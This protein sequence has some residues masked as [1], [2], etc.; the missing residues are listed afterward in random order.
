M[1]PSRSK[2]ARICPS[3]LLL[4]LGKRPGLSGNNFREK[5]QRDEIGMAPSPSRQTLLPRTVTLL[6]KLLGPLVTKRTENFFKK[7]E[8]SKLDEKAHVK[9]LAALE[10]GDYA[11]Y[12]H[13]PFC[14]TPLCKF[15]CF[16]RYAY[17][18][19]AYN[20]YMAAIKREAEWL[21][22]VAE[23]PRVRVVYIGG[24]TPS[25]NVYSLAEFIDVLRSYY[26]RGISVSTEASPLDID[27]E[28]VSVLRSASVTRLSIGVQALSDKR[29]RE[30]GRLHHDVSHSLRAVES[31]RGKFATLNIDMLWGVKSDTPGIVREEA[32]KAFSLGADQ[33]TF[34]P[35]MPAPGLREYERRRREGPWHPL[36]P[37]LYTSIL[38]EA[39]RH[40]YFPATAWCMDRG[41]ELVDE[42]IID[43]DKFLAIGLSGIARLGRYVY[44]NTFSVSRYVKLVYERGFSAIRGLFVSPSEDLLYYVST[45]LFG[46][47]FCPGEVV[48]RFG[49]Q[50][51]QLV[52][53]ITAA[54]RMLGEEPGRD[55]C[56]EIK[57]P[58]TLYLLHVM[59][60]GIYMGVNAFREW[61]LR[62]Q[63]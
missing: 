54:L 2:A 36:E 47:R 3:L 28:A 55:K 26:G 35:L 43:Y 33:V 34:Y 31:A 16:V 51:K 23:N 48:T 30:L 14:H 38:E 57:R 9:Y 45:R 61:G 19:K 62:T 49:D 7:V 13:M 10:P 29:L 60:R 22:E 4:T 41:S 58:G 18:S 46:L 15:C 24:G 50:A 25:I 56:Y 27:D 17:E 20:D 59:Q 21:A 40:K 42:Y 44:V 1:P 11:L 52:S 39:S 12:V 53:A 63:N 5:N 32:G 6:G 37:L 8:E